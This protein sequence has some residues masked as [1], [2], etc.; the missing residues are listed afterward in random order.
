MIC[1]A[2]QRIYA[3]AGVR[4]L[5]VVDPWKPRLETFALT[6][7]AWAQIGT[8]NSDDTVRA[9]PFDAI[10]FSLADLWPLDKPLGFH[11]DPQALYAGDR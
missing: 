4:W 11:E 2:R 9:P 6:D 7:D 10:E 8:W 1:R 3:E 5:W